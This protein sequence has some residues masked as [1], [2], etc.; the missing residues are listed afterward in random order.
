M[1]LPVILSIEAQADLEEGYD[2]YEE[3]QVGLGDGFESAVR[4]TKDRI[5]ES[6]LLYGRVSGEVRCA[7]VSGFKSYV[8]YYLVEDER[9]HVISVFHSRRN[10]R[11]WQR[12]L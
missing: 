9:I 2:F 7:P 5:A 11:I 12:R 3:K 4:E 10:P 6:P 8:L 1:S